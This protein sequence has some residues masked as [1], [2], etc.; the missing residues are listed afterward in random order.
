MTFEVLI[1]KDH[2]KISTSLADKYFIKSSRALI[3]LFFFGFI[4]VV[5]YGEQIN[6]F[7]LLIMINQE[8]PS[9]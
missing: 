7:S 5:K 9:H 8:K 1:Q 6:P 3:F 4:V 2:K